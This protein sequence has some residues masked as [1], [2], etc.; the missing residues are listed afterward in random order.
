MPT[1]FRAQLLNSAIAVDNHNRGAMVSSRGLRFGVF[2]VGVTGQA[3]FVELDQQFRLLLTDG[4]S[5]NRFLCRLADTFN[6]RV[7][8]ILNVTEDFGHRVAGNVVIQRVARGRHRDVNRVRVT[9]EV[10]QVAQNLL[11]GSRQEDAQKI[12]LTAFN[13]MNLES[14]LC[15][16]SFAINEIFE[17]AIRIASQIRQGRLV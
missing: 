6:H 9:E 1:G 14:L 4:S 2:Q 17:L 3:F 13:V 11:V 15:F 7:M 5:L 8:T 10:V 12:L 16:S